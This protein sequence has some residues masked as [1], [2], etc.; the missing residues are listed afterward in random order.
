M[1]AIVET[2]WTLRKRD[3]LKPWRDV[4]A[5]YGGAVWERQQPMTSHRGGMPS[6][7]PAD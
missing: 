4:N 5:E 2:S 6:N 1:S 3:L 7:W